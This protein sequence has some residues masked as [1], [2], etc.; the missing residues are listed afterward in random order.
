M[1]ECDLVLEGGVTSAVVY[2]GLVQR[3]AQD[4]RFR[5]VGGTSAGAVAASAAAVAELARHKTGTDAA[6]RALETFVAELAAPAPGGGT[7]LLELFHPQPAT[8]PVF[9]VLLAALR[10]PGEAGIGGRVVAALRR[11]LVEFLPAAVT[12]AVL[13]LVGY[14]VAAWPTPA[15]ERAVLARAAEVLLCVL[16]AGVTALLAAALALAFA[17]VKGLADNHFGLCNGMGPRGQ[18]KEGL[19]QALHRLYNAL[20]GLPAE[21][22]PVPFGALWTAGASGTPES[23]S[24]DLQMITTALGMRRPFR[25]PNDP[26]TEPLAGFYFDETE[27]REL[28]PK[29]VVDWLVDQGAKGGTVIAEETRRRLLPLPPGGRLPIVVATRLSLSFP[30]LLS[31]VPLY[32]LFSGPT[33]GKRSDAVEYRAR[34][35]YFS[36]GGITSNCPVHLFDAALPRRPTFAVKLHTLKRGE[37]DGR[38]PRFLDG[39]DDPDLEPRPRAK[40]P[41]AAIVDMAVAIVMSGLRWRDSLQSALPGYQE[42]V[43]HVG[44]PPNTGGLNLGMSGDDIRGLS[45]CG[46]KAAE[47]IVAEF[48]GPRLGGRANRWDRHRW[49]RLRAMLAATRAFAGEVQRGQGAFAAADGAP[50]PPPRLPDYRELLAAEPSLEPRL[51]DTPARTDARSLLDALAAL[52][53]SDAAPGAGVQGNAPKPAPP[54]RLTPPW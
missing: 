53:G 38:W 25:I 20:A 24:I 31:A 28:F 29:P 50:L 49:I 27:W 37:P 11:T 6:F 12:G 33:F 30:G 34:R 23:R 22:A 52:P 19:T 46:R 15:E 43:I 41:F 1:D 17:T 5:S 18:S 32:V 47:C 4:Y 21:A 2:A 48:K 44:I 35:V 40:T 3:L 13:F 26:G 45:D 54:L 39:E 8:R 7:H 10:V 36:D 51:V 42:R 14:V 9:A 16:G